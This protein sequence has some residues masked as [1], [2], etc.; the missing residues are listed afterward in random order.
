MV[1]MPARKPPKNNDDEPKKP[2]Q[3]GYRPPASQR[4][5]ASARDAA[6]SAVVDELRL[7]R[8]PDVTRADLSRKAGR[9]D[10]HGLRLLRVPR[11]GDKPAPRQAW[12]VGDLVDYA[13]ALGVSP[14]T[15]LVAAGLEQP[16]RTV[17][18][19]ILA[20]PTLSPSARGTI[21]TMVGALR[22]QG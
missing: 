5:P 17:E 8:F 18:E 3:D 10:H 7:L 22:A 16:D 20:D 15:I 12:T 4:H 6:I 2:Q 1:V 21:L 19:V 9:S 11:G 14:S 13:A